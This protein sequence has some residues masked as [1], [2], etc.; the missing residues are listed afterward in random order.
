MTTYIDTSFLV[1]LYLSDN[2]SHLADRMIKG[3]SYFLLTPL[4]QSEWLHATSQNVFRGE[5]SDVRCQELRALFDRDAKSGLWRDTP[6][7]EHAFDLCCDLALKYGMKYGMRT[8]D[9]LHVACAVELQVERF[10]TF[11]ERQSKLA[12]AAGLRIS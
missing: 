8:L 5:I 2:H 10:W 6:M 7:P 9:T 1:S 4:H 11:D 12:K 3:V